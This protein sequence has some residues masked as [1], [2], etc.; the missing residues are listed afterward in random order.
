LTKKAPRDDPERFNI[1]CEM[2]LVA[3]TAAGGGLTINVTD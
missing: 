2:M 3:G 1:S